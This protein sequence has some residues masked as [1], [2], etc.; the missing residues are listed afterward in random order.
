MYRIFAHNLVK[1]AAHL[2]QTLSRFLTY[3]LSSR[4][5]SADAQVTTLSIINQLF[6]IPFM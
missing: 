5:T 2:S 4:A 1:L 6:H 3:L